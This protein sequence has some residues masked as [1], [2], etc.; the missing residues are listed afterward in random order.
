MIV[1]VKDLV[2]Q[3][4]VEDFVL[5]EGR[6]DNVGEIGFAESETCD[7]EQVVGFFKVKFESNGKSQNSLLAGLVVGGIGDFGEV[8][9]I[10]VGAGVNGRIFFATLLDEPK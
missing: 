3:V 10:N 7:S 4:N 6:N 8:T 5:D 1:L 9:T 2:D